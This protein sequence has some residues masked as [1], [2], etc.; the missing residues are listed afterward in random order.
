[1]RIARFVIANAVLT[2]V[3]VSFGVSA[4]VAQQ[5]NEGTITGI[6]RLNGTIAIQQTQSGTVGSNSTP[7]AEEFRV[8]DR[9]LLEDVHAGDRV[10]FN[11]SESGG[12][13]T[14]TRLE[15]RRP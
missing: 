11:V 13:K 14:I 12:V 10:T 8:Q 9:K 1:M 6:N 5:G 7:A 2:G 4:A 15:R 3:M